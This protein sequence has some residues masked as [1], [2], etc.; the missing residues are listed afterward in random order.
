MKVIKFFF[1]KSMS[2]FQY[3]ILTII[4]IVFIKTNNW[5]IVLIAVPGALI[6]IFFQSKLKEKKSGGFVHYFN[7]IKTRNKKGE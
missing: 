2:Y 6:E 5:L 3:L 1:G 7:E 4:L